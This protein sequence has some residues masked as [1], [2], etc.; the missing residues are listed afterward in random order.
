MIIIEQARLDEIAR[1]EALSQRLDSLKDARMA[2][3]KA[4]LDIPNLALEFVRII[5]DNDETRLQ[6]LE[7]K[8]AEF[9][10]EQDS[11]AYIEK[12]KAEY[13]S[14]E[15]LVVAMWEGDQSKIDELEAIRQA[16]KEKYPKSQL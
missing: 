1:R 7:E 14:I 8:D 6:L 4:G 5:N 15:A 13:P 10:L 11:K 12:R 16:V 9:Q 2:V 3:Y